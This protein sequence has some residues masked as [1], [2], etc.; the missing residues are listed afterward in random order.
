MQFFSAVIQRIQH[1]GG[2]VGY[3]KSIIVIHQKNNPYF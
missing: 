1:G 3:L 2:F